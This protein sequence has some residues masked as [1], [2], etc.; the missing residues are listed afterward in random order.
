MTCL[1]AMDSD[2]EPRASLLRVAVGPLVDELLSFPIPRVAFSEADTLARSRVLLSMASAGMRVGFDGAL[3]VNGLWP[4]SSGEEEAGI[5]TIASHLDTVPTAG[6]Y[7]G[8][9]GVLAGIAAVHA[10]RD[11]GVRLRHGIEVIGFSDEEGTSTL[12]CFGSR[13]LLGLLT[14]DEDALLAQ[15]ESELSRSLAHGKERLVRRGHPFLGEEGLCR[16]KRVLY[17]ELHVEQGPF[18]DR[19][20]VST[21]AVSSI[22]GIDRFEVRTSGVG[23]HAGTVQIDE[24]DD[25]LEKASDLIHSLF[26][27]LR[28]ERHDARANV[29]NVVVLPGNF[30]VIPSQVC[31]SVELRAPD[32]ATLDAVGDILRCL[33]AAVDAVAERV[34]SEEPAGLDSRVREILLGC[35]QEEGVPCISLPSWAGHDAGYFARR[36]PTGMIFVPSVA[37]HSHSEMEFTR[38]RDIQ[39]GLDLLVAAIG[40]ADGVL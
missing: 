21:A 24:R 2:L 38:P 32:R 39:A 9:L 6:H 27:T 14:S 19:R 20:G 7:D 26:A 40:K 12:G 23:G 30:N 29:G 3:N 10:F 37:G 33:A 35:A 22:A 15:A 28:T 36:I 31:L 8:L 16:R 17:L 18:L 13:W 4:A 5:I 11:A 34:S 1:G 25:A